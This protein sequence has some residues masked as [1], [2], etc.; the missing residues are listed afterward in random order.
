M[1]ILHI[2]IILNILTIINLKYPKYL[3][4]NRE[5]WGSE[6]SIY[7]IEARNRV[8]K[9]DITLRVTNSKIFIEILFELLTL[10]HKILN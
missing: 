10:L 8:T 5:K 6:F 9:N 3:I 4:E 7:E 1:L 2:L